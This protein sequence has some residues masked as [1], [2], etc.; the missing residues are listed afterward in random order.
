[1]AKI[2]KLKACV[3]I[4]SLALLL[5]SS[6]CFLIA[7]TCNSS[8]ADHCNAAAE[9]EKDAE[10]LVIMDHESGMMRRILA[11]KTISYGSQNPDKPYC[12]ANVQGSCIG[13]DSKFYKDRP[14]NYNNLCDRDT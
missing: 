5:Y 6:D 13:K 8:A 9:I 12:D 14:C 2:L 4:C 3:Y 7:S 11:T 1:M 10:I